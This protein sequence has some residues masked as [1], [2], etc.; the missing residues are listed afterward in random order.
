MKKIGLITFHASHNNGSMLQA[1]ALQTVLEKKY[2]CKV[3]I[4]NFSNESQRN[5]YA[6]LPKADNYKRLIKNVIWMTKYKEMKKQYK[7]YCEFSGKYFHLSSKEYSLSSQLEELDGVYDAII[8]GSDQVWNIA[9]RDADD[10]YYLN[11]VQKTPKYA[12]AVSFG[13]NNPFELGERN[14]YINYI[15]KFRMISV[16]E[17]MHKMDSRR[18]RSKA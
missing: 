11:F 4:I 13:A 18:N 17:K 7:S 14:K 16:R 15:N 12:Y 3:E 1:L 8:A 5:M 9:C 6:V 10:A 2:N